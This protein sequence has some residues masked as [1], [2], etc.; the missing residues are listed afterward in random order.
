MEKKEF[1]V[2][3]AWADGRS[4]Q[5]QCYWHFGIGGWG[6]WDSASEGVWPLPAITNNI[7]SD[8]QRWCQTL[9][10][11]P[12]ENLSLYGEG[13]SLCSRTGELSKTQGERQE[14]FIYLL[15]SQR[16]FIHISSTAGLSK[17]YVR[18][19]GSLLFRCRNQDLR[20]YFVT[21]DLGLCTHGLN[22]ESH[23]RKPQWC[24]HAQLE[25]PWR[26]SGGPEGNGIHF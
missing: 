6:Q 13:H 18:W 12:A 21:A 11:I 20:E 23:S 16:I 5:P 26:S 24:S 3:W 10:K 19:G 17:A 25:L 22:S 15:F 14:M 7:T 4:S 1:I 2:H 8:N 9:W